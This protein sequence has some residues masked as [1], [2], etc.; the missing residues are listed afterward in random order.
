MGDV[1]G[2]C[3]MPVSRRN[4]RRHLYSARI[5]PHAFTLI[6]LIVV[7][8]I[9][10]VLLA[11][12]GA[13]LAKVR[14]AGR[15]F[16]C[17]N[18]LKNV[19]F[20]FIQFADDYAHPW[21]GDSDQSGRSGFYIEDF[22]ERQYRI[23][24]FWK[25]DALSMASA[26]GTVKIKA[27][28]MPLMCPAGPRELSKKPSLACREQA[29][30]PLT[31]VSMGFNMRLDQASVGTS[32]GPTQLTQVR[33]SKRILS[34]PTVPLVFDVDAEV[35]LAKDINQ[36][37]YYSAPP[38]NSW[39]DYASGTSWFPSLRHGGRCNAAFIG[40]HVLSSLKPEREPGWDWKYQPPVE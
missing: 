16:V 37:P 36:L 4:A 3:G 38:A 40:G 5:Q 12:M 11:I 32:P 19:A 27:S 9:L 39:D 21:R 24:E 13:S 30:V 31:N 20:D 34:H 22:Q 2:V 18:Q 23:D 33:L 29:I 35:A 6:E 17:K 8:A 1:R 26:G 14:M 15:S 25:V 7:V 10:T 28:E